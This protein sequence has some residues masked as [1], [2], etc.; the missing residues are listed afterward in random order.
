MA[1][2]ASEVKSSK[3]PPNKTQAKKVKNN[4]PK[5]VPTVSENNLITKYMKKT[6]E[7]QI[8]I[9]HEAENTD[10][11]ESLV[12]NFYES[13]LDN[14]VKICGANKNCHALK[15]KLQQEL[16][17]LTEKD[18]QVEKAITTCLRICSKKDEEIDMLDNRIK[19]RKNN[20]ETITTKPKKTLFVEFEGNFTDNQLSTLRSIEKSQRGDSTFIL[21]A[22]RFSYSDNLAKLQK[23]TV[24][25]ISKKGPKEPITPQK[26][27]RLKSMFSE[28][29]SDLSLGK[30]EKGDREKNFCRHV[31][32]AITN[33][34]STIENG[35]TKKKI[36][37]VAEIK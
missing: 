20:K 3:Q 30:Q 36:I 31:N 28:R 13:C 2:S 11:N 29:L 34:C 5:A 35:T 37:N 8:P 17:S 23:K 15:R 24:T 1:T 33:V 12:S 16:A 25:G 19:I 9:E 27:N 18:A 22:I 21:N 4:T 14:K 6:K 32:R 7:S 10:G 26:L